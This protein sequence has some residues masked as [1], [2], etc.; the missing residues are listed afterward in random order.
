[1]TL[2]QSCIRAVEIWEKFW[3]GRVESEYSLTVAMAHLLNELSK[4]WPIVTGSVDQLG[5]VSQT[6]GQCLGVKDTHTA[7]LAFLTPLPFDDCK[8]P[9]ESVYVTKRVNGVDEY[10][11]ARC[12]KNL[13]ARYEV[14]P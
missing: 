2:D 10:R 9:S 12:S 13:V 11:C 1:M 6:F 4:E 3:E 5:N 7:R 8:H 14:A